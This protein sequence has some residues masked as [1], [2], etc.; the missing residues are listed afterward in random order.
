MKTQ[1]EIKERI[2]WLNKAIDYEENQ[3]DIMQAK[4][5]SQLDTLLWVLR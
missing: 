3:N 5:Y 2:A 4:L 1:D